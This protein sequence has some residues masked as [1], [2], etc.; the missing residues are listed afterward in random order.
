MVSFPW[1]QTAPLCC[2]DTEA[3]FIMNNKFFTRILA[4]AAA[5]ALLALPCACKEEQPSQPVLPPVSISD[6]SFS[7]VSDTDVSG[8]DI[9]GSDVSDSDISGSDTVFDE[10][11]LTGPLGTIMLNAQ[12]I[13]KRDIAAY[14]STIDPESESYESTREDA[15][16]TFA[17]YRLT[18]SVLDAKIESRSDD[19]AV[20]VVTQI[21]SA[22]VQSDRQSAS[23]S[24][25]SGTD[26]SASDTSASDVSGSDVPLSGKDLSAGFVPCQTTL[27]HTLRFIDGSWYI[28]STVA[29][30][31]T[32]LS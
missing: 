11:T 18:V 26:V 28:T 12:A 5:C 19:S 31:Y 17:H 21:T 10:E 4:A 24:D 20:V 29:E 6:V 9:S 32:A 1:N 16:Y 23:G 14:M 7:D 3:F 8:T 2:G 22:E 25:V 15:E 13:E 27:R 30:S